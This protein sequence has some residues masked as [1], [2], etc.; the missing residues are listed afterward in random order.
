M[1]TLSTPIVSLY[2]VKSTQLTLYMRRYAVTYSAARSD[3]PCV[4]IAV[5]YRIVSK[6]TY[7]KRK[8]RF[9]DTFYGFHDAVSCA[10]RM[11]ILTI[12][13]EVKHLLCYVM[14]VAPLTSVPGSSST[15]LLASYQLLSHMSQLWKNTVAD[16]VHCLVSFITNPWPWVKFSTDWTIPGRCWQVGWS[17]HKLLAYVLNVSL[18]SM[19]VVNTCVFFI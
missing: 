11:C 17:K 7:T 14:V 16:F 18:L 9:E 2:T 1:C 12:L 8:F 15:S 6:S 10:I 3:R 19:L 4:A 13:T 5:K